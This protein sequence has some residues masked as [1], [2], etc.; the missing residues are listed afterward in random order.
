MS[1]T[2][3][4]W[5]TG[6]TITATKLNKIE[7]GIASAGG[8]Y[9]AVVSFYHDNNSANDWECSII[10]GDF[11]TIASMVAD[12]IAPNINIKMINLLTYDLCSLTAVAIYYYYTSAAVPFIR[13]RAYSPFSNTTYLF[14]WFADDTVE[15]A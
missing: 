4:T 11:A 14:N 15:I 9:D 13:F 7:N 12:D 8:G 6:D 5:T 2:P 3:T 10:S 1:Y